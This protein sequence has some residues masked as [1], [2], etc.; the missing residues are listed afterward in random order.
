MPELNLALLIAARDWFLAAMESS[1]IRLT[2][3]LK[4]WLQQENTKVTIFVILP[5]VTLLLLVKTL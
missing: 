3:S 1:L 4:D 5:T 2:Q